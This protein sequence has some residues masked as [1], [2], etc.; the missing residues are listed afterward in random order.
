MEREMNRNRLHQFL[1]SLNPVDYVQRV[2]EHRTLAIAVIAALTL[3]FAAFIPRL[4]FK[5]SIHDL[6][7]E[8]LPEN[9]Q[10]ESF[11][12]IFGSEEIIRVVVK[13]ENVFDPLN[14][15]RIAGL[16]ETGKKIEGVQRVI[17]LPGIKNAVD[18]SGNWPMEKFVAFVSG[19]DLFRHN[20]ISADHN[21]TSITLVLNKDAAQDKVIDAVDRMIDEADTDI[22]LY[23]I[24]MPLISQALAQ[25]TK[26]DFL[27]LPPITFLLIAV[28][29]LLLFRNV[30]SCTHPAFLR[31]PLPDLDIRYGFHPSGTAFDSDHDRSGLFN[32]RGNGLL[33]AYPG[34]IS[35]IVRSGPDARRSGGTVLFPND[36][37]DPSGHP[38]HRARP[39]VP[40]CQ[41]HIRHPGICPLL[42]HRDDRVSDPGHDLPARRPLFD[43]Q[44]TKGLPGKKRDVVDSGSFHRLDRRP[45]PSSP[46]HDTDGDRGNG[47]VSRTRDAAP[48]SGD[49]SG[50]VFQRRHPGHQKFP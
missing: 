11:K 35:C 25:F 17:G 1:R 15:Q 38:D 44:Q 50:R 41:P 45:E 28:V 32:R 39:G 27:R 34:R 43:P 46:A 14:F 20:L 7:I 6:I 31:D 3:L 19:V 24:G 33:P 8:D 49:Q 36:P 48:E 40:F 42:V 16:E 10:Y 12:A 22:R 29:L 26:R 13:C 21:T 23:Q 47:T 9:V 5:T 4:A 2:L 37:A 18:L 30:R